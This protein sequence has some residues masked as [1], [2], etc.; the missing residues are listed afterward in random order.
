MAMRVE[1]DH[2]PNSGSQGEDPAATILVVDDERVNR[3]LLRL[4]LD[5]LG[6]QVLTAAEGNQALEV[7]AARPD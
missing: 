6:Y 2:R 5:K 4:H 3:E 7:L 1:T